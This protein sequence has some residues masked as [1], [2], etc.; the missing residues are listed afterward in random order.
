[1][2]GRKEDRE[3]TWKS[4]VFIDLPTTGKTGKREPGI[5]GAIPRRI[6]PFLAFPV[7]TGK[8]KR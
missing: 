4:F 6:W 7:G 2:G 1:M 5:S 3:G 8:P